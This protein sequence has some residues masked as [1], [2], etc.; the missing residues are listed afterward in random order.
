MIEHYLQAV[1]MQDLS[2]DE[3]RRAL[4]ALCAYLN[5]HVLKDATPEYIAF[6]VRRLRGRQGRPRKTRSAQA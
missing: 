2:D 4:D 6:E 3:L 5:V 1:R